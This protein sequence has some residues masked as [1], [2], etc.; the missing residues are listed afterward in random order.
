MGGPKKGPKM[1]KKGGFWSFS[2]FLGGPK[3]GPKRGPKGGFLTPFKNGHFW[4][5]AQKSLGADSAGSAL[6]R[7]LLVN[8]PAAV[9]RS[10]K[11]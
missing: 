7:S 5:G 9:S 11:R 10:V 4:S 1:A 2:G 3:R 6:S 8:H